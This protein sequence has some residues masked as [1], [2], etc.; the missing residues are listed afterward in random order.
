MLKTIGVVI[1]NYV[2]SVIL[3]LASDPLLSKL[4]PG[5][6]ERGRIPSN[7]ALMASTAFFVAIAILC[8]WLCAKFAPNRAGKH[9]LW[10]FVIGEVMGIVSVIPGWNKGWLHWYLLSWLVAWPVCCWIGLMISGRK[11]GQAQST[12]A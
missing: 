6:F 1:G 3:V 11:N 12:A 5:D 2:L 10:F 8:A 7:P 4:F 9:V